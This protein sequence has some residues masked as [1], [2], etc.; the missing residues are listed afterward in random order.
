MQK[1]LLNTKSILIVLVFCFLFGWNVSDMSAQMLGSGCCFEVKSN[2]DFNCRQVTAGSDCVTGGGITRTYFDG[3]ICGSN[4]ICIISPASEDDESEEGDSVVIPYDEN[5]E[6]SPAPYDPNYPPTQQT[7]L[8]QTQQVPATPA[9]P[10]VTG[11]SSVTLDNPLGG[12][13]TFEQVINS[14]ITAVLGITGVLALI[15]FIYGG[16]TW[17]ISYG[18]PGKIQK[19]KTMMVWAVAGLVVIFSAY[20]IITF[21]FDALGI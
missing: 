17:M 13:K 7:G 20:A 1:Y 9:S 2:S 14:V 11:G 19:G 8:P 3:Q 16:L 18:D 15:A 21:V 12:D 6:P 5:P 4:R 10:G